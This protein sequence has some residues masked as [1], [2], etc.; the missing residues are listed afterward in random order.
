MKFSGSPYTIDKDEEAK[1][2]NRRDALKQTLSAK[3]SIHLTLVTTFG[4]AYNKY[5]GIVQKSITLDD[6]FR[7]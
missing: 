7:E 4:V 2:R 3:Q 5:S 1:L 6:L